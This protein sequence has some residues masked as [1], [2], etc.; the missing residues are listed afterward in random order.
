[1]K[2]YKYFSKVLPIYRNWYKK[3]PKLHTTKLFAALT[4]AAMLSK[5]NPCPIFKEALP[6]APSEDM[7]QMVLELGKQYQLQD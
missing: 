1:M 2:A 4:L 3:Y 6:L 7:K 5:E